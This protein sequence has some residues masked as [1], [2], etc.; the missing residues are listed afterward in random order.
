M[1][2]KVPPR[3]L[4]ESGREV[5]NGNE[6]LVKGALETE[7]GVHLM[8]GYPGSPVATFFDV[9]ADLGDLLKKHGIE[10]RLANNEALAV[11][12]A[13]GSQM[14]P[15]R[16]LVVFKSVGLHVASDALALGN[17]S[18]SHPEGGVV[19]VIG[20]DPW[21][22]STQVPADS[23]F[24]LRHLYVPAL[25]PST[26]QEVKD[27]VDIG[28]SLSR[29]SDLYI[30]YVVTTNL[31]DG[32]GTVTCRPNHY[33]LTNTNHPFDLQ[34]DTLD[35]ESRVLL[36]PR[37][38]RREQD[39]PERY[40]RLHR[41]VL[42]LGLN[43]LHDVPGQNEVVLVTSGMGYQYVLQALADLGLA[44]AIPILKLDV[45]WPLD[46][47]QIEPLLARFVNLLVVEERRS[48]IDS[49][50]M[51]DASASTVREPKSIVPRH[52]GETRSPLRPSRR[53]SIQ[54]PR[55][56][57]AAHVAPGRERPSGAPDGTACG[58]PAVEPAGR[59]THL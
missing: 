56:H 27:F 59:H 15:L 8:T 34:T 39:L 3:F 48:F 52:R 41:E 24:L 23:R 1:S 16:S 35:L 46:H 51:R 33:P 38:G 11:A 20:D 55:W 57:A 12:A 47:R 22:E 40:D 43:R 37:T 13:N 30:D 31:A 53:Y 25:E 14:A 58:R 10:C 44:G 28:F 4:R 6:L 18:G 17:L 32:G 36:P 9:L 54:S 29:A 21:S 19:I 26:P 2:T 45:T 49:C 42:R 5:F 50:T 7:G